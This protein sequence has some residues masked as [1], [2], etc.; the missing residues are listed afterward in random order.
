MNNKETWE[1]I[2]GFNDYLISNMG[3][4]KSLKHTKPKIRKQ[5]LSNSS[6]G[7]PCVILR[8]D[9]NP[10]CVFVH[11]LVAKAFIPNAK[12][13]PNVNHIDGDKQNNNASNLEWVTKK[14]NIRHAIETGL[15]VLKDQ[16]GVKNHI[17]KIDKNDVLDIYNTYMMGCFS[18]KEVSEAFSVSE[19]V[20]WRIV[21]KKSYK[22][23][24]L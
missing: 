21:N 18:Q 1:P 15:L 6:K 19:S 14:E 9:K 22:N 10:K 24:L 7:Y 2:E 4:V 3:R 23:I 13:K 8:K 12:N 16:N 17:S 5:S 20:V 11:R